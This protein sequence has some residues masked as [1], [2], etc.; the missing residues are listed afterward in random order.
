MY[1]EQMHTHV[2]TANSAEEFRDQVLQ[3]A[4]VLG[5]ANVT[6]AA[7]KTE[8]SNSFAEEAPTK[9]APKSAE[10]SAAKK[11]AKKPEAKDEDPFTEEAPAAATDEDP[12][13]EE[14]PA[15]PAKELTFEDVKTALQE[16]SN[17]KD[18]EAAKDIMK[19]IG[20]KKVSAIEKKDYAKVMSL[21]AK[22]LK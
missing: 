22:A 5:G 18:I 19:A 3:L 14:A 7:P 6:S 13:A 1:K 4:A 16:V 10:K 8:L 2:I 15:A 17:E 20:V 12:F 11:G 9:E 21:C